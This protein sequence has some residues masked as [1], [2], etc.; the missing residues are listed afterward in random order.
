M[1]DGTGQDKQEKHAEKKADNDDAAPLPEKVGGMQSPAA[2]DGARAFWLA[3]PCRGC[4]WVSQTSYYCCDRPGRATQPGWAHT[5]QQ[6]QQVETISCC[7]CFRAALLL[8]VQV[9]GGP[10]Y[11]VDRKLGKGGFGQVF[12]GRRVNATK[13]RDGVNANLVGTAAAPAATA[14]A[15]CGLSA[16]HALTPDVTTSLQVALKF[17]HRSS[18]GCNYGP[19]YEWSV[20]Q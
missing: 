14:V 7:C 12:I 19:P 17:E 16:A 20:Y 2:D 8:Q 5:Q 18:K 10:E 6:Q 3:G 15:C 1:K 13:Q 9:G 4:S 11:Y